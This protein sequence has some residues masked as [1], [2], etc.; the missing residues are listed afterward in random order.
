[1]PAPWVWYIFNDRFDCRA[2]V[3]HYAPMFVRLFLICPSLS[4]KF[5]LK[6]GFFHALGFGASPAPL[7]V[8]SIL[9][10]TSVLSRISTKIPFVLLNILGK[11]YLN[12][13]RLGTYA[14]CE[15]FEHR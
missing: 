7:H 11:C 13:F 10:F 15:N 6:D 14:G 3:A 8:S 9:I 5:A 12:V 2:F 1:M 4:T